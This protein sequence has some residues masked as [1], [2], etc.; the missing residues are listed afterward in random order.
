MHSS[1]PCNTFGQRDDAKDVD[2][3]ALL[4]VL[5]DHRKGLVSEP[6]DADQREP[7]AYLGM[8]KCLC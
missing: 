3:T 8:N 7:P 5:K 2:Y 1:E 4:A 6:P